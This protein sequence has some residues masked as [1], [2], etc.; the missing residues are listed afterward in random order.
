[1]KR[2]RELIDDILDPNFRFDFE[3]NDDDYFDDTSSDIETTCLKCGFTENVP[4]FIYG[5]MSRKKYHLKINKKVSTLTC[6]KCFKESAIP[7]S[8]L[9]Q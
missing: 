3:V 8:F 6:Q 9:K 4:D 1:M 2:K 7:S 5:E